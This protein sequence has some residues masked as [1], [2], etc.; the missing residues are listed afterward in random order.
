[1]KKL[2]FQLILFMLIRTV[3]NSAYRMI[4]AF[5]PIFGRGLGVSIHSMSLALTTRA[6]V[7][8][9]GP[10]AASVSDDRGRKFGMLFGL[11]L[12]SIGTGLVVFSP[13][14]PVFV[15][16]LILATIGKYVFDPSMQAYL[17]D[18]VS[19]QQRGRVLAVTE[20]GWSLAFVLG[21]PLAG[22]VIARAGWM[23][24]FP[25]FALLGLVSTLTLFISLPTDR[26][27][28]RPNHGLVKNFR[29][30]LGFAP[31][32]AAL[33]IG[34]CASTANEVINVVFGVWLDDSLKSWVGTQGFVGIF[35]FLNYFKESL[36]LNIALLILAAIV[37]GLSELSAEGLVARFV[38]QLGKPR[39]VALGL[40]IN[41][42]AAL[43]L[44]WLGKTTSG[45][46]FG[47]FMFYISF[48]FALV[49]L[50]P[51]M[52]EIMPKNRATL[53]AFNV[54]ALSIG[55]AAG[56]LLAPYLYGAGLLASG[57]GAV[58]FNG[59]ALVFLRKFL[60]KEKHS[61]TGSDPKVK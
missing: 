48:E 46:L 59:V 28:E 15:L 20:F 38:D 3:F 24:P 31:A 41:S 37:I 13:T 60:Q 26:H 25:L 56:A 58:L 57:L 51:M 12:F 7:S 53:M 40:L 52:T 6:A 49:S 11:A 45:A 36:G 55:R 50:I 16:S 32:L 54:A 47:L 22:Y 29:S 39:A 21:I 34:V 61:Q 4:Y 23:A 1:V 9:L 19:Y 18:R 5:L 33:G 2:R 30:V 10:F 8:S 44:P 43:L 35:K 17:G 27:E 14:F 42:L